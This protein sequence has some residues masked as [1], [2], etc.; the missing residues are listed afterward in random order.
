MYKK[1]LSSYEIFYRTLGVTMLNHT[2]SSRK[3]RGRSLIRDKDRTTPINPPTLE[4]EDDHINT[5]VSH[6]DKKDEVKGR[7]SDG[8]KRSTT[9][10]AANT[11]IS[12]LVSH[13]IIDTGIDRGQVESPKDVG[14]P[15]RD[16]GDSKS[17][18]DRKKVGEKVKALIDKFEEQSKK[19][20][21]EKVSRIKNYKEI[22]KFVFSK[23]LHFLL[24]QLLLYT[25]YLSLVVRFL[26][27]G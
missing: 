4:K 23:F 11:A 26:F 27:L 10:T 24:L 22:S 19:T 6:H 14:R 9:T 2:P 16:R 3:D 15:K 5:S 13:T 12:S 1:C 21:D 25:R 17:S 8:K 18:K 20:E 7:R